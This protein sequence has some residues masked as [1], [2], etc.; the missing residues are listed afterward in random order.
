[1]VPEIEK[2]MHLFLSLYNVIY[3]DSVA[4]SVFCFSFLHYHYNLHKFE[5][6]AFHVI[7]FVTHLQESD[8][9]FVDCDR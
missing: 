3:S 5:E 9:H 8:N 2:K 6:N 4:D 7:S 1:M